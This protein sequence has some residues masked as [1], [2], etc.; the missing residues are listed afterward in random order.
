MLFS[1]ASTSR[2]KS[3][4]KKNGPRVCCVVSRVKCGKRNGELN[5]LHAEQIRQIDGPF[6]QVPRP[7]T[8]ARQKG[9]NGPCTPLLRVKVKKINDVVELL[10][11]NTIKRI[12][13][14]FFFSCLCSVWSS[15]TP[16][17]PP[18]PPSP[19]CVSKKGNGGSG[20]YFY[21]TPTILG[22][23]G[24]RKPFAFER[25]TTINSTK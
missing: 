7:T 10:D 1:L 13:A 25:N 9:E 16:P 3:R 24:H 5:D 18:P 20:F 2:E 8:G 15:Y 4:Q 11:G 6:R 22:R 14:T 23:I 19:V 21:G 17:P 12:K